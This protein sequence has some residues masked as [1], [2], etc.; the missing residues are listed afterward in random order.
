MRAEEGAAQQHIRIGRPIDPSG[1]CDDD[2]PLPLE[3]RVRR[4]IA[5][6]K[7][8]KTRVMPRGVRDALAARH[9]HVALEYG[10]L[11]PVRGHARR[12]GHGRQRLANFVP[13]RGDRR[14]G[15]DIALAV[16]GDDHLTQRNR[17]R[18]D[19]RIVCDRLA[20][21]QRQRRRHEWTKADALGAKPVGTRRRGVQCEFARGIRHGAGAL[22]PVIVDQREERSRNRGAADAVCQKPTDAL[23]SRGRCYNE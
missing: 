13:Q 8:P 4:V 11:E 5:E 12:P 6:G 21:T 16:P 14:S 18:I 10:R 22:G 2:V 9:V 17:N 20:R 15:F 7:L 1:V 19:G 23:R 3:L